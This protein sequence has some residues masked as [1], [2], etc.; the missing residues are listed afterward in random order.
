[1]AKHEVGLKIAHDIPVGNVDV[2]MPIKRDGAPLGRIR[3]SRGGVDWMPSPKSKAGYTLIWVAF[4]K[5][6][7]EHGQEK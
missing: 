6:M 4:D 7:K 1:M 3:V 5:L 2:E